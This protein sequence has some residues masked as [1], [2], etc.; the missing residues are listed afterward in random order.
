MPNSNISTADMTRNDPPL[1]SH[2]Y[3]SHHQ[4]VSEPCKASLIQALEQSVLSK[5]EDA[6][7]LEKEN[8]P[9]F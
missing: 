1:L 9:M 4:R 6:Q 5:R 7:E 8:K 3:H 2:S